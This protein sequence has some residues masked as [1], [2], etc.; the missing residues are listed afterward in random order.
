M[1][2][3]DGT[4]AGRIAWCVTGAG[5]FLEDALR[6]ATSRDDVDFF[7]SRA[8]EEVVRMYRLG[9]LLAERPVFRDTT[10]S[11]PLSGRFSGGRY[12]LLVVAPAT[13][14]SV[15]K[16]VLGLSD[17][18][19]STL[20]AQAGKSG[21]PA[22]VLPT[23]TVPETWSVTPSGNRVRIRPRAVD[24]EHSR[25]LASFED[26]TVVADPEELARWLARFS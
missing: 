22:L 26:V 6:I 20:F 12:R 8:A 1:V 17:S 3:R 15:A 4:C 21:V 19:V 24:L 10:A 16:F 18:L 23:D 11:V 2:V 7:L 13:S 9:D 25:R 14:N 5:H